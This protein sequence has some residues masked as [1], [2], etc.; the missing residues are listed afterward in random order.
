MATNTNYIFN[1]IEPDIITL[2]NEQISL[3]SPSGTVSEITVGNGLSANP[4]TITSTGTITLTAGVSQLS[5]TNISNPVN[6]QIL[7][8]NG[9]SWTNTTF[10]GVSGVSI[11]FTDLTD[12][13]FN[14]LV[15]N[16]NDIIAVNSA[17][18]SLIALTNNYITNIQG[19]NGITTTNSAPNSTVEFYPPSLAPQ[20]ADI[21][22]ND[23]VIYY[24]TTAN[25]PKRKTFGSIGLSIFDNDIG[26]LPRSDLTAGT[27]IEINDTGTSIIIGVSTSQVPVNFDAGVNGILEIL[28]G[29]TSAGTS[30]GARINLGLEYN[31]DILSMLG[32]SFRNDM[33]GN[34]IVLLPS[35]FG[36]S[37]LTGGNNYTSGDDLILINP[38]NNELINLG[39]SI[40]TGVGDA[41]TGPSN[42]GVS[43]TDINLKDT[44]TTYA[45]QSVG[46]TGASY[47]V[48]PEPFY[49]LFGASTEEEAV[50]IR[51]NLGVLELKSSHS[52]L[53]STW[54]SVFPLNIDGLCDVNISN[55]IDNDILIYNGTSFIN[56]SLTGTADFSV[57]LT[58]IGISSVLTIVPQT[59]SID[60]LTIIPGTVN[61][62][63]FGYLD[64]LVA[65]IQGQLDDKVGTSPN[66]QQAANGDLIVNSSG[67]CWVILRAPDNN[68]NYILGMSSAYN[69][70]WNYL[71]NF[72]DGPSPSPSGTDVWNNTYF[73][74]FTDGTSPGTMLTLPNFL[75]NNLCGISGGLEM[76]ASTQRL[77]L[78]FN[79]T[80]ETGTSFFDPPN[81]NFAF[82]DSNANVVK[83]MFID[84]LATQLAGKNLSSNNGQIEW[85]GTSPV[86][87][88]LYNSTSDLLTQAPPTSGD[89]LNSLAGVSHATIAGGSS[90]VYCNG[91]SWFYVNLGDFIN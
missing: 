80:L 45:V 54:R 91:V 14:T 13:A 3:N 65:N 49:L 19:N 27:A 60:P 47:Q 46:G 74:N 73:V 62:T 61:Q 69:P 1:A 56:N 36:I 75:Q 2:I 8:F 64:G 22:P 51:N 68:S 21:N 44:Q 16:E 29:G 90:L 10:P 70:E 40:Q 35:S 53:G 88:V 26:F 28:N 41:I 9:T 84:D 63:E 32:P 4:T 33:F 5:D 66:G 52:G 76:D 87:L 25:Q 15:G 34:N 38:D 39:I 79:T 71:Y 77:Q 58:S 24:D 57:N 72:L 12:V 20:L 55:V 11:S 42:T 81:D 83:K 59:N 6:T 85:G 67:V 17:G 86:N 7:A 48:S 43:I 82:Y 37:L 78:E 30:A 50:G 31:I 89:N 18:T 23:E